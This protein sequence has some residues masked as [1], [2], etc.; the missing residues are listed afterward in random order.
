MPKNYTAKQGD[1]ISSIAIANGLLPDT[2]WNFADNSE[3]RETRRSPNS[4]AP[5]DVVVIPDPGAKEYSLATGASHKFVRK[6]VPEEFK[7]IL[8]DEDGE[9]RKDVPFIA[10][11]DDGTAPIEG[12]SDGTG[13]VT[14]GLHPLVRRIKLTLGED[15]DEVHRISVGNVD[16]VNTPTGVRH[17]LVNL[18]YNCKPR[19]KLDAELRAVLREFQ[20]DKKLEV[21]GEIDDATE[22]ALFDRYG[23]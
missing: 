18:G 23:C 12:T 3:L 10:E 17:R 9:P 2:L 13:L 19:G 4:L 7:L 15:K 21:S 16:P 22:S 8:E 6:G 14:F 1:C 20:S 5:G 11:P